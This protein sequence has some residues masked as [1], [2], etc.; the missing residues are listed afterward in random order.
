MKARPRFTIVV[1]PNH[2]KG[3]SRKSRKERQQ[4]E[5]LFQKQEGRCYWCGEE[6]EMS[7]F[8]ITERGRIKHNPAFATFEHLVPKSKGG[9]RGN[10]IVL[11]HGIC[12][13]RRPQKKWPHDPIYSKSR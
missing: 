6:M 12:N 8:R 4:R 1:P 3:E 5:Q 9:R 13:L 7:Q 2:G 11:A 10:N